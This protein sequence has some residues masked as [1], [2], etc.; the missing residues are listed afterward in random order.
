MSFPSSNT[1]WKTYHTEAKS[2]PT[3]P[4]QY[5]LK[6]S[7]RSSVTGRLTLSCSPEQ[8]VE[9]RCR[10]TPATGSSQKPRQSMGQRGRG[11][12]DSGDARTTAGAKPEIYRQWLYTN[13][14]IEV[15]SA[16]VWMYIS[17]IRAKNKRAK[18]EN[19]DKGCE[20]MNGTLQSVAPSAAGRSMAW[21]TLKTR[22]ASF[23]GFPAYVYKLL[24]PGRNPAVLR[25]AVRTRPAHSPSTL[26]IIP[27][28]GPALSLSPK[29]RKKTLASLRGQVKARSHQSLP[30]GLL[31]IYLAK[32][33]H[34]SGSSR[35]SVPV[36]QYSS[37]Y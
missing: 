31:W 20:R 33:K 18:D 14:G 2:Q 12:S 17:R 10:R 28:L 5:V 15:P 30:S 35:T 19:T 13:H 34:G 8:P 6:T 24:I 23:R 25:V 3:S 22:Q 26:K 9:Y 4:Q 27:S 7:Y 16:A 29:S 37:H 36:L 1:I 11:G 32:L 21:E